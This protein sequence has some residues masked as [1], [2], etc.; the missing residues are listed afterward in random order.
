MISLRYIELSIYMK[1]LYKEI[2]KE[3]TENHETKIK[4]I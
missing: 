1:N 3:K 4:I 2:Y